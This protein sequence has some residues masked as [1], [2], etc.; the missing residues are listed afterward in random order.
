MLSV[1]CFHVLFVMSF[2]ALYCTVKGNGTLAEL[3]PLTRCIRW[4]RDCGLRK[5]A[6]KAKIYDS[7]RHFQ[8]VHQSVLINS[9]RSL[10]TVSL[11]FCVSIISITE[12]STFSV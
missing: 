6:M 7:N 12:I 8:H 9:F 10:T 4:A 11:V 5:S 2:M 1:E 3:H